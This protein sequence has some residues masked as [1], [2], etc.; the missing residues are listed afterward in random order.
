MLLRVGI[1]VYSILTARNSCLFTLIP[2][3]VTIGQY[4]VNK[5]SQEPVHLNLKDHK[6]A[7]WRIFLQ[8]LL[9]SMV[10]GFQNKPSIGEEISRKGARMV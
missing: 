10:R 1:G 8:F 2:D 3:K 6:P 9:I 7:S 5:L 4:W